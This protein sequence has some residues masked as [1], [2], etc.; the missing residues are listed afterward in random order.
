MIVLIIIITALWIAL[1]L[2]RLLSKIERPTV[3][4]EE[5]KLEIEVEQQPRLPP[6][7]PDY[8]DYYDEDGQII[9]AERGSV[10]Y[11]LIQQSLSRRR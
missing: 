10:M 5:L 7:G 4:V 3:N 6:V 1:V 11:I 9:R 8:Y 2:P